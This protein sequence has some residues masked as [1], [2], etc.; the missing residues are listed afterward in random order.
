MSGFDKVKV[1]PFSDQA[2]PH[3]PALLD[4]LGSD[5][6]WTMI[7]VNAALQDETSMDGSVR[8]MFQISWPELNVDV[9]LLKGGNAGEP[10][11]HTFGRSWSNAAARSLDV[12]LS[13]DVR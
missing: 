9:V 13:F 3:D 1:A 7:F 2:P 10:P 12:G 4:W 11:L 6:H 8:L 5:M